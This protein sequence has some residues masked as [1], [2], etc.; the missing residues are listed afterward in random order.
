[1]Y[2]LQEA[3]GRGGYS[4]VYKCVDKVGVRY[5]AKE[6]PKCRNQRER[7]QNEIEVMKKLSNVTRV[8][9]YIDAFEDHENY[10]IIQEWCKGGDLKTYLGQHKNLFS[11]NFVAS[12]LRGT[13]RGLHHVHDHG[14]VHR[15][16]KTSNI[17]FSDRTE[18]SEIKII[19]FG[20]AVIIDPHKA[21]DVFDT[22]KVGIVGTPWFLSPEALCNRVTY[23]SDLWSVGIMT[24]HMLS[25]VVPFNDKDNLTKPSTYGVFRSV[26]NDRLEFKEEV[27]KRVS[28]EAKEFIL[29]CLEKEWRDRPQSASDALQSEWLR[30]TDCSDRFSG[31][32]LKG[33][34][35]F[36]CEKDFHAQSIVLE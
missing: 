5:V 1:M 14:I 2:R 16:I 24:Y 26:F 35:P 27:W 18:D 7:V 9:R 25:G 19:D 33:C 21:T 34:I 32:M 28:N 17:M 10:Y 29:H 23:A 22:Y 12:V 8:A 20:A 15:D 6:L 31:T 4:K 13:L 30:R 3:I 36:S 11:E